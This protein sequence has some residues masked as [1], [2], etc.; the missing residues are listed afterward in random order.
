MYNILAID[1]DREILKLIKNALEIEN[2]Q[3]TICQEIQLPIVFDDFKRYDLILLDIMMPNISGT[4][5][6]HRIRE[7]VDAPIIFVSALSE[8]DDVIQALTI[9]GDDFIM[10]PFNIKQFIAR[11]QSHLKRE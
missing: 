5:F 4:E 3:V 10:K 9:G 6:C 8:D 2:Y 1:D 11:V 7:E